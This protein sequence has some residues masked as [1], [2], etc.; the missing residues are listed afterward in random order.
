[1]MRVYQKNQYEGVVEGQVVETGA[2][3]IL[4]FDYNKLKELFMSRKQKRQ[5]RSTPSVNNNTSTN[6]AVK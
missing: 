2:T 3:F 4:N 6:S 1:M 5:I